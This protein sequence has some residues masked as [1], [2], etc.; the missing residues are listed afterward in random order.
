MDNL[1]EMDKFLEKYN[2]PKLNQE[3]IENLNRP[4]TSTEIETVIKNLPTNKSPGPDGFTAEF[5][6]NFREELPRILL[7][8]FQKLAEEG[9]LPNSFYEATITLIPKSDKDATKKENSIRFEMKKEKLQ[10]TTQ[11]Y[12]GS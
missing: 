7:K 8:F 3:E 10:Q 11:K 5:Y 1:E 9:K 4:I 2:L 12:K 6:Q